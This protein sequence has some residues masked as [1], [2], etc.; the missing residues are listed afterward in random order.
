M[1]ELLLFESNRT[2]AGVAEWQ[3]H[4]TQNL[5]VATSYGFKSHCRQYITP[6]WNDSGAFF[7]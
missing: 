6:E 7:F 1:I 2:N 3:T 4:Q 5:A